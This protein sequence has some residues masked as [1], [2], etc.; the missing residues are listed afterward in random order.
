MPNNR[1]RSR[2]VM[3]AVSVTSSRVRRV[4]TSLKGTCTVTGTTASTSL[5]SII[6]GSGSGR[7]GSAA[8]A[9]RKSVWPA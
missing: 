8:R 9:A 5:Q 7:P 3:R 4:G 1:R 2:S 6:T